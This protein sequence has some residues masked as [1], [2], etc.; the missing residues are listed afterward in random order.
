MVYIKNEPIT[1]KR[2]FHS[3]I[4]GLFVLFI[5]ARCVN[6]G[7]FWFFSPWMSLCADG[8]P[9]QVLSLRALTS[10]LHGEGFLKNQ[11]EKKKRVGLTTSG[12][13]FEE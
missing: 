6:R 13:Y 12:T 9:R 10:R 11:Q 2:F 7:A 5:S 3:N 1:L 4:Y 8:V